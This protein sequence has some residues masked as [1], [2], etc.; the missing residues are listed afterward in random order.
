MG[1]TFKLHAGVAL[2]LGAT[3]LSLATLTWLP[4]VLPLTGTSS[5][6]A[7][8]FALVFLTFVS[9]LVR[10]MPRGPDKHAIWLAFRCLPGKV[11]LTLGAMALWGVVLVAFSMATEGNLQ[12]AEIRNGRYVA[13]DMTPHARGTVEISRSQYQ[14]VLENDH[15]T[16]LAIPGVLALGAAYA[17]LAAGELHRADRETT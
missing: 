2:G 12:S 1:W 10:L 13:F 3:L 7:A 5:L 9:A 14:A 8:A 17:V 11:Q 4:G 16:M 6:G 15:R